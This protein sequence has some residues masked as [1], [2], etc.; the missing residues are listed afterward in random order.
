MVL[1]SPNFNLAQFTQSHDHPDLVG[2]NIREALGDPA[3]MASLRVSA[4]YA[5][6]L[7]LILKDKLALHSGYRCEALNQAVGSN[8]NSQHRLGEAFDFLRA[9]DTDGTLV[10]QDVDTIRHSGLPFHQL[11]IERGCIHFGVWKPGL[12]NGEVAYWGPAGKL[13]I[14]EASA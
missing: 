12:P 13:V 2:Q 1:L 6:A 10:M 5:E 11:L 7:V 8:P 3:I 14:Q 9:T 4:A